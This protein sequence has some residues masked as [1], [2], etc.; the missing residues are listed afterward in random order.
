VRRALALLASIALAGEATAAAC[1]GPEQHALDF[2]IGRWV[3]KSQGQVVAHSVIERAPD[4]C[5][6]AEHYR[7]DDGYT[8]TSL[9]FYDAALAAWRQTWVD[10]TGAIG[11]FT[12]KPEPGALA[13]RGETHRADGTRV[14]RTMRLS[15]EGAQVR[16]LS[17]A[18]RD[19][20]E[21]KPHYD[22]TYEPENGR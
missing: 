1:E 17:R 14:Q 2:W 13:F 4:A 16:Q 11:E 12:G 8:G 6:I 22:F 7:Q 9:S 5:A 18:S 21:W 15:R 10:S 20:V 19:G 3:V